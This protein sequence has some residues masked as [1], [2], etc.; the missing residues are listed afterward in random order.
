MTLL[1]HKVSNIKRKIKHK[2]GINKNIDVNSK[3]GSKY[4]TLKYLI[5]YMKATFLRLLDY[6]LIPQALTYH[7]NLCDI[8]C[9]LGEVLVN[10]IYVSLQSHVLHVNDYMYL[11]L[12]LIVLGGTV[13]EN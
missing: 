4:C 12:N 10:T 9:L 3:N 5:L 1:L 8:D 13:F 7:K 2:T 6:K 11:S